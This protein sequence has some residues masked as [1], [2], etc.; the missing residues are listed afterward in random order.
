MVP[1]RWNLFWRGAGRRLPA[2]LALVAYLV[3]VV[4]FPVP[5]FPHKDSGQPFPC[6]NHACGCRTAEECWR[7]CCCFTP[8]ERW[9]WAR[10]HHV[11][12]PPY[13]EKPAALARHDGDEEPR[14]PSACCAHGRHA[15]DGCCEHDH[16]SLPRSRAGWHWA[17]GVDTLR[18][19]GLSTL[20]VSTGAALPPEAPLV[21]GPW[22][23]PAGWLCSPEYHP[24]T[25][26]DTP[27]APPPR[28]PRA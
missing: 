25:V 28:Q 5:A 27:P 16:D 21:W 6:Q 9:A 19:Q 22:P 8:E 15:D 11:E 14:G 24:V 17:F 7:H 4:G 26:S 1:F 10:E 23:V 12:P 13:A 20:W 3:A 18:C 2:G